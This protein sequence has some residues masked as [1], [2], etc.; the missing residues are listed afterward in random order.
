MSV[1]SGEGQLHLGL[2]ADYAQY[3]TTLRVVDDVLPQRRL[4]DTGLAP[5]HKRL[6][7]A[8][9]NSRHE[10]VQRARFRAS[11]YQPDGTHG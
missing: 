5:Q 3:P 8:R 1:H 2:N 7:L 9:P 11:T 4:A 6:A 10:V